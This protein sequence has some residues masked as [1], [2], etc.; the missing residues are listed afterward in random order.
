MS[1]R[2]AHVV[3]GACHEALVRP[4]YGLDGLSIDSSLGVLRI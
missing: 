4:T 2:N 3:L 1:E